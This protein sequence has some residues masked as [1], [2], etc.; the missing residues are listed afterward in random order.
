M[1]RLSVIILSTKTMTMQCFNKSMALLFFLGFCSPRSILALPSSVPVVPQPKFNPNFWIISTMQRAESS[2]NTSIG[3]GDTTFLPVL[4]NSGFLYGTY[5]GFYT[6]DS[7]SF[8]LVIALSGPQGPIGVV[9]QPRQSCKPGRHLDLL[10][11]D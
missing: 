8:I 2:S 4:H 9:C 11:L 10:T 3:Q 1:Q 5:F 6:M 7:H